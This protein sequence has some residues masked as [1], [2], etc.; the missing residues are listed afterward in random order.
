[1][2][3]AAPLSCWPFPILGNTVGN[4]STFPQLESLASSESNYYF[5]VNCSSKPI[6][7]PHRPG[8]C[9]PRP[10]GPVGLWEGLQLPCCLV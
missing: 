3:T 4:L 5:P 1:M 9:D 10:L 7:V 2:A 8:L 6:E